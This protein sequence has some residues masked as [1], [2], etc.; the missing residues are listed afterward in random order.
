MHV[1]PLQEGTCLLGK[2]PSQSWAAPHLHSA[3]KSFDSVS[4]EFI[5][6]ANYKTKP[7]LNYVAAS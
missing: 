7:G 3:L 2:H 1:Y 6:L 5:Q 4:T